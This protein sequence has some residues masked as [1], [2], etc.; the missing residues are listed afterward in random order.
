MFTI[1]Q[2]EI[3]HDK[4]KS[5]AD[6]PNYIQEIKRLGVVSFETCVCDSHTKY[7]SENEFQI[8]SKPKYDVLNIADVSNKDQFSEYLKIHQ[9]GDTDYFTFCNHC[10]ETGVEKWKVNLDK[11]TCTYYDKVGNEILVE[12]VPTI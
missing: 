4:V 11:I 5:G 7:F 10:A 6:F 9:K 1:Q 2:I 8:K 12:N 3:A